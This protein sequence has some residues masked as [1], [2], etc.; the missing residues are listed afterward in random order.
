MICT[1]VLRHIRSDDHASCF[2][3]VLTVL[4]V[5]D[6]RPAIMKRRAQGQAIAKA[7]MTYFNADD[8]DPRGYGDDIAVLP[9]RQTD[10][11]SRE[12]TRTNEGSRD[13]SE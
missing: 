8:A 3:D 4:P 9:F 5:D 1:G 6:D 7:V 11:V 12:L 2:F 10:F 13:V